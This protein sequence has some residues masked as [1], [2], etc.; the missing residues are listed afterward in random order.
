MSL[1]IWAGGVVLGYLVDIMCAARVTAGGQGTGLQL[2]ACPAFMCSCIQPTWLTVTPWNIDPSVL[3]R[4][5]KPLLSPHAPPHDVARLVHK[6]LGKI[7]LDIIVEDACQSFR[8]HASIM[9]GT[10]GGQEG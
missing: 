6:E 8:K 7:P 4:T 3:Q 1:S 2:A 9:R 10:S 5:H